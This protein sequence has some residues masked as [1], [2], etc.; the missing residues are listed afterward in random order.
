MKVDSADLI[1]NLLQMLS[2][3]RPASGCEKNVVGC[4]SPRSPGDARAQPGD[5]RARERAHH[6]ARGV[7]ERPAVRRRGRVEARWGGPAR[8][9][10]PFRP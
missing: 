10:L 9:N 7:H 5:D 1:M 6:A 8:A 4:T 2:Y 3:C